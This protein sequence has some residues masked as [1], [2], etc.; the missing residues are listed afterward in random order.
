MYCLGYLYGAGQLRQLL[1]PLTPQKDDCIPADATT[2]QM[3]RIFLKWTNDHTDQ[4]NRRASLC[5]WQ[6]LQAA[7]PC[8]KK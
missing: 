6:A 2:E 5:V 3:R 8:P 4:L 1:I 7:F